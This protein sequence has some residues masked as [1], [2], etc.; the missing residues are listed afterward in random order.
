M[1]SPWAQRRGANHKVG[2]EYDFGAA[3]GSP[4]RGDEPGNRRRA[5]RRK[6]GGGVAV[7]DGALWG[8]G[9]ESAELFEA[10]LHAE[11][12]LATDAEG[13]GIGTGFG[14]AVGRVAARD[15]GGG[16]HLCQR[17]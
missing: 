6:I 7:H 8:A 1:V 12:S 9:R 13:F 2:H 4:G 15:Y 5:V 17:E 11:F 10:G 14:E 16:S 3:G